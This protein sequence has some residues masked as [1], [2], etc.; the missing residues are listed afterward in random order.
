MKAIKVTSHR[1][2]GKK[3]IKIIAN[4]QDIMLVNA[5]GFGIWVFKTQNAKDAWE[6]EVRR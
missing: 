3:G 2:F 6:Q 4:N 5:F 1:T